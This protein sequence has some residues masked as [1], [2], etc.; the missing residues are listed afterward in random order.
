MSPPTESKVNRQAPRTVVV[1]RSSLTAGGRSTKSARF[2]RMRRM[3]RTA[4]VASCT[5]PGHLTFET[6][7]CREQ[8]KLYSLVAFSCQC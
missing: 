5:V 4:S 1:W 8:D 7:M 6:S 2:S 3:W